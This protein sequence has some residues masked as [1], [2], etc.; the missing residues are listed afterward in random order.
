[1]RENLQQADILQEKNWASKKKKNL[2]LARRYNALNFKKAEKV[3]ACA[4]VLRFRKTVNGKL[5]LYQAWLCKDKLCDVCNW[6]RSLVLKHKASAVITEAMKREKGQFV[7]LTLTIA[8]CKGRDLRKTMSEL[9]KAFDRMFKRRKLQKFVIGYL[10]STEVTVNSKME[11]HPHIHCLIYLKKEYFKK[12]NYL[13]Q[14]VLTEMWQRSLQVDYKPILD[15][16]K[17]RPNKRKG[18]KSDIKS[19]VLEAAKYPFKPFDYMKG[20]TEEDKLKITYYLSEG[21]Y[22]K[23]QVSFGRLF[24]DILVEMGQSE[25]IEESDLI[26][27]GDEEKELKE[28]DEIIYVWSHTKE[29]YYK[30]KSFYKD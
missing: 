20:V 1:M 15:I 8:N 24:K 30:E 10:R 27:I 13:T 22:K 21:L 29:N 18:I 7:F 3:F 17:I 2:V 25:D 6:R 9:T 16:R 26:K 4:Q 19:A 5:K 11:F 14:E 12:E 23:R 28:A